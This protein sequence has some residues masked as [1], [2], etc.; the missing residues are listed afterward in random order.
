M[1]KAGLGD[2]EFERV[3]HI[4]LVSVCSGGFLSSVTTVVEGL[5]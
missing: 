3:G 2:F 4:E 1:S 5:T